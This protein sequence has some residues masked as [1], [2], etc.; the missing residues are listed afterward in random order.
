[1]GLAPIRFPENAAPQ[2]DRAGR[3]GWWQAPSLLNEGVLNSYRLIMLEVREQH[4]TGLL[5][6]FKDLRHLLNAFAGTA[7]EVSNRPLTIY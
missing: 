2:S 3:A 7:S 4:E 1:M 5:Q 6:L